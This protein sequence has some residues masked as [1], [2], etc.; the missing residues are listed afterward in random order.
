ME[1]WGSLI[2]DISPYEKSDQPNVVIKSV[3]VMKGVD[4]DLK[5]GKATP[6][7]AT[8]TPIKV[9]FS[10]KRGSPG[11]RKKRLN[12]SIRINENSNRTKEFFK[13][14][15]ITTD[16]DQT[17]KSLDLLIEQ[18]ENQVLGLKSVLKKKTINE[19]F[20]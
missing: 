8:F 3:E 1:K 20:C 13:R 17:K 18:S 7:K 10:R 2:T 15:K 4:L 5:R 16:F 11:W 19:L 9:Q 12:R 6:V 14:R